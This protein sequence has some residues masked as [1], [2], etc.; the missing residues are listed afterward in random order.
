MEASK[1]RLVGSSPLRVLECIP[2]R[3]V[4][5]LLAYQPVVDN[6]GMTPS[7]RGDRP[8][9][10]TG[11]VGGVRGP[12][13]RCRGWTIQVVQIERLCKTSLN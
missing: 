9:A 4:K 7:A 12:I 5:I 1:S 3:E 8:F 10:L 13:G 6:L 11:G 2:R